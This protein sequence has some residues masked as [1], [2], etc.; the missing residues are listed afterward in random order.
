MKFSEY[1]TLYDASRVIP[2][3]P[4]HRHRTR[5]EYYA[6]FRTFAKR[7]TFAKHNQSILARSCIEEGWLKNCRP[8]YKV[9]PS[10]TPAL[11]R[12]KLDVPSNLIQK[13][14]L[15]ILCVRLSSANTDTL[16]GIASILGFA[17]RSEGRGHNE[18]M[19][20][21]VQSSFRVC[22]LP[23]CGLAAY[24]ICEGKSI[25]DAIVTR[26]SED[27]EADEMSA[28]FGI[29]GK[30]INIQADTLRLCMKLFL[31][32]CLLANDPSIIRPDVLRSDRRRYETCKDDPVAVARLQERA[33]QRGKVGWSIGEEYEVIPHFRRPHPALVWTQKG[34]AVPKIIMRKGS[35]VHR[36]K[37][38]EV[39]TG[40]IDE[41]GREIEEQSAELARRGPTT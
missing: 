39:P 13:P 34:R 40:Y 28:R 4:G 6:S 15:P 18:V 37:A 1:I 35:I 11:L 3:P 41:D 26:A 23:A 21:Y 7:K 38:T 36:Q 30:P 32:V 5:E 20:I 2:A 16:G 12:L 25:D 8:Y 14:P 19:G 27:I 24:E 17:L 22:D 33:K 31:S 9:W 10:L 29:Q